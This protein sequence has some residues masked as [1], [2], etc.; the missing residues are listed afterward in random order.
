MRTFLRL[1]GGGISFGQLAADGKSNEITA[2]TELLSK[3]SLTGNIVTLDAMGC[4]RGIA[5]NILDQQADY[6][7]ALC[8]AECLT[9]PPLINPTYGAFD[10][11]HGRTVHRRGWVIPVADRLSELQDWPGLAFR[12]L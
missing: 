2:I 12:T 7:L 5:Q 1:D 6:I 3:L 11:N 10:D 8:Q 4:Q 9:W